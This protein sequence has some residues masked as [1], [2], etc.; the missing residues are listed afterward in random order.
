MRSI[1]QALIALS[2]AA[3]LAAPGAAEASGKK[4]K[5]YSTPYATGS[6]K[7][8][9]NASLY[10]EMNADKLPFGTPNWWAQMD[11]ENRGGRN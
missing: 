4:K 5:Y 3:A 10:Y 11:R 9:R 2:L 6:G 8:N 7:A 1:T